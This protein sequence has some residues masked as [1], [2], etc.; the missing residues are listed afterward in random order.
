MAPSPDGAG[1]LVRTGDVLDADHPVIKGR[2]H[3]FEP[4]ENFAGRAVE[5]ASAAPGERR[6]VS[7]S[8]K[9]RG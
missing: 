8:A 7:T 9:S 2:E 4:V 5:R 3:F 1:Y 6:V